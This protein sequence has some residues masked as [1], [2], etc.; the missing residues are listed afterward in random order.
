MIK[1]KANRINLMYEIV[2]I[3]SDITTANGCALIF[4]YMTY[5][6]LPVRLREALVGGLLLSGTLVYLSTYCS[7]DIHWSEVSTIRFVEYI[8]I[9]LHCLDS[10]VIN[11]IVIDIISYIY[12][13][14]FIYF[15]IIIPQSVIKMLI[16]IH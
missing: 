6:M 10:N 14:P 13:F 11:D 16:K 9:Y 3:Y 15:N 1:I 7:K 4:V 12:R 8:I 2:N 5:T